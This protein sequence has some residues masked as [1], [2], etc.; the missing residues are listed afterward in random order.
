MKPIYNE[1]N[2]FISKGTCPEP[3]GNPHRIGHHRH[4]ITIG[5]PQF[6]AVNNEGKKY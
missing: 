6:N 3:S 4:F 2:V 1:N 5:T